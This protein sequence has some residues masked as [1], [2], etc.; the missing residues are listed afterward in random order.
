MILSHGQSSIDHG[1][2]IN[3]EILDENLQKK[4]L[5]SQC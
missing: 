2:S 5:L 3:K 4:W 1:F